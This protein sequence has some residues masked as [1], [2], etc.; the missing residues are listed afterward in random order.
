MADPSALTNREE[1]QL[2]RPPPGTL[3]ARL[4]DVEAYVRSLPH[5]HFQ[6]LLALYVDAGSHLLATENLGRR[7]SAE[8]HIK[9]MQIIKRT[10]ELGG[11]GFV[12]AYY[13]PIRASR[14]S[15]EETRFARDLRRTGEDFD[16]YLLHYL[17]IGADRIREV[18]G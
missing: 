8:G 4:V 6:S 7:N 2:W 3:I 16:T 17:I 1:R 5:E 9:P 15:A 11:M 14:P 18:A 12:I 13:D 10:Q